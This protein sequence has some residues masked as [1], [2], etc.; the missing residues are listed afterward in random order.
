MGASKLGAGELLRASGCNR[1][2]RP[3]TLAPCA[4]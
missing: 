4:G 1:Y 2:P 3:T